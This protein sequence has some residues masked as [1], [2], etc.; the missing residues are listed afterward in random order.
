MKIEVTS[1]H[2]CPLCNSDMEKGTS[3]N[4]PGNDVEDFEMTPYNE[5]WVPNKC[6]LR[7]YSIVIEIK[8]D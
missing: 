1:C 2:D 6:P 5:E 7:Q 8:G 3:C 4:Y